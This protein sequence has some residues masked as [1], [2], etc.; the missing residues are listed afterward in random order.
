M[1]KIL[2]MSLM[3]IFIIFY[4]TACG[5]KS[6][7]ISKSPLRQTKD[8]AENVY[9]AIKNHDSEKLKEQ[10]CERLQLGKETAVD[11]IYEYIDGEIETLE[12][13]FETDNYADAGGGGEIKEAVSIPVMAKA[14]IG[15]FVEAQIL[16]AIGIDYID[17]SEVLTPADDENHIYKQDFDIPFVCGARNLGEALRRIGEGASMIRTKGEAGTGNV[18][19]AVRHFRTMHKDINRV[20]SATSSELMHITKEMGAPFDLVCYVHEHGKLPV[21]NFAAGGIAT[22]AD[23]ALMMQLGVDGVFVGSGIFKSGDPQKRAKAIVEATTFYNDPEKLAKISENLGEAMVGI[24]IDTIPQEQQM[25]K[26]GW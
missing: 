9:D 24:E 22:P 15:H 23:A 13:D 19:E 3:V 11:K 4:V 2:I 12:T 7:N 18:V 20:K 5:V 1:R 6:N 25:A 16:Q 14:R 8:M 26:R 17:E 10:F 21:V